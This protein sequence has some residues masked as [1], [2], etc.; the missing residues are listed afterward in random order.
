MIPDVDECYAL[1][2]KHGVPPHI[3][4]HSR[5]VHDVALSLC[6]MLNRHGEKLDRALVEAGSL[7]HDIAK[8]E[9]LHTGESH[10]RAGGLLLLRLGYSEVAEIV[11][12]H[13]VLD[14]GT[15]P[16]HITETALVHYADKRVRHTT[17]VSL[18]ER[19]RD[20]KERYGKTS[21]AL[22][23]LKDMEE[24]SLRLEERIF[25]RLPIKPESLES[26]AEGG[27]NISGEFEDP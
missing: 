10:P 21:S 8:M 13:V 12:Q 16:N 15:S 9:G 23:W 3:I 26:L 17:V 11:R 27:P 20:L 5:V 24:R 14:D 2:N 6:Q 18:A 25:Q 1:L 4:Q 7:L 22:A 19:F